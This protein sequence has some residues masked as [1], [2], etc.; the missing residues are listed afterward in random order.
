MSN[1]GV[2]QLDGVPATID[3]LSDVVAAV[4]GKV[5][6]LLDGGI[7]RGTDVVKALALGARAVLIGR[8]YVW[9]LAADGEA[10]IAHVLAMLREEV[11]VAMALVGC[12]TV[13]DITRGHV[14]A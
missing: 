8:P 2:R 5:E 4:E 10:G 9:G 13:A 14:R 7:W 12:P 1:H 11:E 3:C 6:V